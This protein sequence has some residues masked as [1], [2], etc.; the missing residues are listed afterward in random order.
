MT[1]YGLVKAAFFLFTAGGLG[2][3]ALTRAV[4]G[5]ITGLAKLVLAAVLAG[6]VVFVDSHLI[7]PNWIKVEK[8]VIKDPGLADVAGD[9]TIVQITDIHLNQGGLKFLHRQLIRKVNRL[10]P[11]ILF[12]TGDVIDDLTEI[13]P[14]I[15][16]FRSFKVRLGI[17]AIPGDTDHIV[18]DSAGMVR[19]L[20]PAGIR[21]LINETLRLD[22]PGGKSLWLTGVDDAFYFKDPF[23]NAVR[24]LPPGVPSIILAP[25]PDMFDRVA[26]AKIPLFLTGD[27]HGG[28]VGIDFLIRMSEYANRTPYMRGLFQ[29][30]N[31][32]MYVNR[33]I[34]IKALPI[35]FLC[36]PE[37]AVIQLRK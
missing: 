19:E 31:T 28:Q 11:D 5:K 13:K 4:T 17:F 23:G 15:E 26:A 12:F 22:L 34:G 27:T 1:A 21:W 33:G 3:A 14:A 37:I 8:V 20:G 35:R 18:L 29:K 36:R 16:L 24:G 25:S 2:F 10:K 32:R 30:G 6:I 7:E 9:L